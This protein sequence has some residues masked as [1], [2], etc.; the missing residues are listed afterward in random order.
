MNASKQANVV[1]PQHRSLNH[2]VTNE[3]Q[4]ERH[5]VP[6]KTPNENNSCT[7]RQGDLHHGMSHATRRPP[8][9]LVV[10]STVWRGRRRVRVVDLST[11]IVNDWR[12]LV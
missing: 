8:P 6:V 2:L 11:S 5:D 10:V 12:V 3:S 9:R 1:R 4:S 7:K